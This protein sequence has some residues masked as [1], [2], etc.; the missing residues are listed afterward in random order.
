VSA[1]TDA[2]AA[3]C[4]HDLWPA[5]PEPVLLI[6]YFFDKQSAS[7]GQETLKVEERQC[8]S[9]PPKMGI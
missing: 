1:I 2:Q 6:Q 7:S 3:L 8:S 9:K 4:D 5:K